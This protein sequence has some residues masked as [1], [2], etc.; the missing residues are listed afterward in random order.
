LLCKEY[1][2]LFSGE[3]SI[4]MYRRGVLYQMA[5]IRRIRLTTWQMVPKLPPNLFNEMCKEQC[6]KQQ[7]RHFK[8]FGHAPKP[9]PTFTKLW[10][11]FVVFMF[12]GLAVDWK[13]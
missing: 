6:G 11:S 13:G 8:D 5:Q 2:I 9:E 10:Y 12:I 3:L 1:V 4:K 7:R